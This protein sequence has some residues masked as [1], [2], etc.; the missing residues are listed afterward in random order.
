MLKLN[1]TEKRT[2]VT[3]VSIPSEWSISDVHNIDGLIVLSKAIATENSQ[4]YNVSNEIA[5]SNLIGSLVAF[6]APGYDTKYL[7]NTACKTNLGVVRNVD[8]Y[9]Q[10]ALV[11]ILSL[12]IMD[13]FQMGF[14]QGNRYNLK[15]CA[16]GSS[17]WVPL[18]SLLNLSGSPSPEEVE[19][20]NRELKRR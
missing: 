8:I 5:S 11:T 6:I 1:F 2:G 10:K 16:Q 20:S 12:S 9:R 7:S 15:R 13:Y 3:N 4:Q 14:V 19:W 18:Y 17:I